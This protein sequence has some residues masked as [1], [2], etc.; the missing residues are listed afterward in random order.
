MGRRDTLVQFRNLSNT[1]SVPVPRI[2]PS[3]ARLLQCRAKRIQIRANKLAHMV[4]TDSYQ[5]TDS[6]ETVAE[7]EGRTPGHKAGSVYHSTWFPIQDK[8]PA[9]LT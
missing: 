7:K 2:E 3:P 6:A 8:M 1:T 5:D 4:G 9:Q